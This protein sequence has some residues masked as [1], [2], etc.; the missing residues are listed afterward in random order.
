MFKEIIFTYNR[1]RRQVAP[2]PPMANIIR[3]TS[4]KI[5]GVSIMDGLSASG[6]SMTSSD[7]V[8]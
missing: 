8:R 3:T 1:R 2:P 5:L 4:L 7:H 6:V